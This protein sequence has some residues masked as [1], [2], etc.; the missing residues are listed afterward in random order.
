MKIEVNFSELQNVLGYVGTILNDK[1]V[2]DKLKNVIFSITSEEIKVIGYNAFTFS[3]TVL[4]KCTIEDVSS[5][6]WHFQ[7]K[8]SELN[9]ILGSFSSMYKTQVERLDFED[10]GVKIKVTVHEEAKDSEDS[11]LNQDSV[12]LLENAPIPE[13]IMKEVSLE[14]T[15]DV[16][17]VSSGDPLLY[18]DSLFPLMNNDTA[19]SMASKLNFASDYVF[20][21]T[22]TMS[23]FMQ[24]K[25][26]DAFKDLTLT[27]SSA[28]FLKKLCET[29]E[30]IGVVKLEKYLCVQSGNTEAFMKFQAVRVNYKTYV[31]KLNKDTGIVIDR[32][33]LKDVLKRM[34]NIQ[35]E[36]KIYVT[37]DEQ[38]HVVN[39]KFEQFIPL[40]AVKGEASGI[41][42]NMSVPI[43]DKVIVGR[44]DVF[45]SNL[46]MYFV[47][48]ARGYV[49]YVSDKTGAWFANTQVSRA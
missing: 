47:E 27:Y 24:N 36:G 8:A 13:K 20:I 19:S 3:R 9:K 35:P 37:D 11:R 18:L 12:F 45:S 6:G 48:T 21:L 32:L 1:S 39:S 30:D 28:N 7:L 26:P 33:Y 49:L 34:G 42:F 16:E 23:A 31:D 43:L 14:L 22:S 17:L 41:S 38:L 15:G 5:D 40:E 44:D 10:D 25:L 46:F 29:V 4:E 2:D